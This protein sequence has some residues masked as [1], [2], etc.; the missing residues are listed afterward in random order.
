MTRM[1]SSLFQNIGSLL[2]FNNKDSTV[3]NEKLKSYSISNDGFTMFFADRMA[4]LWG[5]IRSENNN[6]IDYDKLKEKVKSA[7]MDLENDK[8]Q[9]Y[10]L[11]DFIKFVETLPPVK[12]LQPTKL[13][14]FKKFD[15]FR[16]VDH[17]EEVSRILTERDNGGP[18]SIINTMAET[19]I[20]I[21]KDSIDN[22]C[23]DL[24]ES[25]VDAK[26]SFLLDQDLSYFKGLINEVISDMEKTNFFKEKTE[27]SFKIYKS[28]FLSYH[29]YAA[30]NTLIFMF[31]NPQVDCREEI[32]QCCLRTI[33]FLITPRVDSLVSIVGY[34]R[35]D[36]VEGSKVNPKDDFEKVPLEELS[37][38]KKVDAPKTNSRQVIQPS[39]SISDQDDEEYDMVKWPEY[40]EDY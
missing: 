28:M 31:L 39:K 12:D 8:Q 23:K 25:N 21:F 11:I 30:L 26:Q 13:F 14:E 9:A 32:V 29:K 16:N 10:D 19:F 15:I 27:S 22:L 5:G 1:F 6:T 36:S 37:E 3:E 20:F 7:K 33:S 24:E 2:D 17:L 18:E 40:S 35:T 34:Y 38:K 4:E